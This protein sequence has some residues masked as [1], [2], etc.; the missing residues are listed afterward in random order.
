MVGE[1]RPA[2]V[3]GVAGLQPGFSTMRIGDLHMPSALGALL[4]SWQ[5]VPSMSGAGCC[6]DNAAMESFGSTLKTEMV[7]HR[8][9]ANLQEARL[10]IFDYIELFYNPRRVHRALGYLTCGLGN[11]NDQ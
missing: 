1:R 6:Y 11:P 8:C 7:H 3:I 4:D 2:A 10:A 9:F 5:M